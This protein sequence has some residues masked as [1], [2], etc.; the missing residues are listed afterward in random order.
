MLLAAKFIGEIAGIDRFTTDSQ[1]ARLAGCAPIPGVDPHKQTR[2]AAAV[3]ELEHKT[4]AGRPTGNEE[5]AP[6]A[7]GLDAERVWAVEDI[8]SVSGLLERFLIERGKTVVRLAPQLMAGARRGAR[9]PGKSD[10]IDARRSLAPCCV[11]ACRIYR[12]H[13]WPGQRETRQL[14]APNGRSGPKR[15]RLAL[16]VAGDAAVLGLWRALGDRDG[17]RN[18]VCPLPSLTAR[19]T[20]RSTGAQIP[21]QLAL[22]RAA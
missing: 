9:S 15:S 7:R 2:T 19:V 20:Q 11:R 18:P 12:P 8:R 21:G 4:A 13:H 5:L 3:N 1:L 22:E 6:R 14:G 10:P 16:P 17:A